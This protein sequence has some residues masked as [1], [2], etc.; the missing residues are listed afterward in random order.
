MADNGLKLS[1]RKEFK[2]LPG[3]Y[4]Y[5]Y[6]NKAPK[7]TYASLHYTPAAARRRERKT[8]VI[9]NGLKLRPR[10]MKLIKLDH[11]KAHVSPLSPIKRNAR[12]RLCVLRRK[13][14]YAYF[15]VQR[16]Y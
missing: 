13:T 7:L 3:V 16:H 11:P 15:L 4:I 14:I 6:I 10:E 2:V 5:T 12:T 1:Q 9:K 8:L